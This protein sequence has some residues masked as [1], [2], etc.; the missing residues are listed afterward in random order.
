MNQPEPKREIFRQSVLDRLSLPDELDSL[1]RIIT[2]KDW[3]VLLSLLGMALGVFWWGWFGSLPTKLTSDHCVL[4]VPSA[5]AEITSESGGGVLQWMVKSGDSVSEGTPLVR[6]AS[7][8]LQARLQK[9]ES[10]LHALKVQRPLAQAF[11]AHAASLT[12]DWS[13]RQGKLL[14]GQ[15]RV[16]QARSLLAV[17]RARST[18][19]LMASQDD[20]WRVDAG[21][22]E[23]M[24]PMRRDFLAGRFEELPVELEAVL[25]VARLQGRIEQLDQWRHD[26]RLPAA[27]SWIAS[28]I[29][30]AERQLM[31]LNKTSDGAVTVLSRH[32]G[33][34]AEIKVGVG[35]S[36]DRDAPLLT[37]ETAAV[38]PNELQALVYLPPN[39]GLKILT[40]MAVKITPRA[41]KSR[42]S[43]FVRASVARVSSH[44]TSAQGMS[45]WS[46]TAASAHANDSNEKSTEIGV[47]LQPEVRQGSFPWFWTNDLVD[48]LASGTLCTAEIATGHQQPLAIAIPWL[49]KILSD[50]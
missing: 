42:Q 4:I 39:D 3:I 32:S 10:R 17:E 37:I 8:D 22:R 34:V 21:G 43:G 1:T 46:K 7:P 11:D 36:V 35:M 38:A 15:L 2:P 20:W 48:P 30:E 19:G 27:A 40:G 50:R 5:L 24:E 18:R 6:L 14:E 23:T 29:G 16:A 13:E 12:S 9:V 26:A 45:F 33:R 41:D 44:P 49:K 47:R 25:A 31:A 28:Q